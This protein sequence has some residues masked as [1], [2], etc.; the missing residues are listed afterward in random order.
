MRAIEA[1]S[2]ETLS[3]LRRTLVALRQADGGPAA[4]QGSPLAPSPG[5]ADIERLAAAT[6]DAG[7][8]ARCGAAGTSVPYRPTSG[9]PRTGSCRR[10]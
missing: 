5:L 1:T 9:S 6:A 3:G 7:V 10:R 8:R 4:A 2:R